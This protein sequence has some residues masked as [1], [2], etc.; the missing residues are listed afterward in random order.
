MKVLIAED[1]KVQR[2]QLELCLAEWGYD[3]VSVA[4]GET[5]WKALQQPEAPRL[6]VLDWL[7]PD[8][9]GLELCRRLRASRRLRG[10]FVL[11]VTAKGM[12]ADTADVLSSGVDGFLRKPIDP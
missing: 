4:D 6:A 11:I 10:T 2:L 12:T 9:D 8:P 3:V 1:S 5:A 7:M